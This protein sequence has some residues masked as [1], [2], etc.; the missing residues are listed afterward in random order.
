[1][2]LNLLI[3]IEG[4]F[5]KTFSRSKIISKE[6]GSTD[7]NDAR[8]NEMKKV[9]FQVHSSYE[10]PQIL[11]DSSNS[12]D[13]NSL[14]LQAGHEYFIEVTPFGQYVTKEIKEMSHESRNCLLPNEIPRASMLKRYSKH[15]CVYECKVGW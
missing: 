13:M 9:Y 6:V 5:P 1:M 14:L 7:T 10:L 2:D 15:N 4:F 12:R 11:E 8:K 3:Y